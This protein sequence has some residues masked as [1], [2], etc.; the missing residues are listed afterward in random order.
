M[1]K[2]KVKSYRRKGKRVRAHTRN[3][4]FRPQVEKK[5]DKLSEEQEAILDQYST[6]LWAKDEKLIKV[7]KPQADAIRKQFGSAFTQRMWKG[8]LTK[9][10]LEKQKEKLARPKTAMDYFRLKAE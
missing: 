7:L 8:Q 6:A 5:R 10:A 9:P 3:Y 1:K 2:I 4:R